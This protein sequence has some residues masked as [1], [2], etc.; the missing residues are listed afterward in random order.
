MSSRC[1]TLFCPHVVNETYTEANLAPG[2]DQLYSTD[3]C[4]SVLLYFSNIKGGLT[5]GF[6]DHPFIMV[7]ISTKTS[8][9]F[10]LVL[11][12]D[13]LDSLTFYLAS[14]DNIKKGWHKYTQ[15]PRLL[16]IDAWGNCNWVWLWHINFAELFYEIQYCV[17]YQLSQVYLLLFSYSIKTQFLFLV[18]LVSL[19][20]SH[21]FIS[22]P[23]RLTLP[24]MIWNLI[25][26][27]FPKMPWLMYW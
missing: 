4:N 15:T 21:K 20:S 27:C 9:P 12:E 5:L 26:A 6:G 10:I 25:A 3:G 14:F 17:P 16:S 11:A 13:W 8:G 24:A 19:N 1:C 23:I 2:I 7:W 18:Q 22:P